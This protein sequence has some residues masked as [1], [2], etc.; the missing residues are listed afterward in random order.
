MKKVTMKIIQGEIK[1][2][3]GKLEEDGQRRKWRGIRNRTSE[4]ENRNDNHNMMCY[5]A[6]NKEHAAITIG[7][8]SKKQ[9]WV[10]YFKNNR[11]NIREKEK[12]DNI[13][14]KKYHSRKEIENLLTKK[15]TKQRKRLLSNWP[16]HFSF[17]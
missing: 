2:S 7:W 8:M 4:S 9:R 3:R 5:E 16:Q 10:L 6:Q 12:K 1:T 11:Q 14:V 13:T 17:L 15:E